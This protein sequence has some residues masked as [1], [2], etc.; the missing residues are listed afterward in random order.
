VIDPGRWINGISCPSP[1]LCVVVD[2]RGGVLT[3]TKPTGG[4][5]A[6]SKRLQ[7]SR[8]ALTTISCPSTRLCVA[9]EAS[10]S[11]LI[12]TNPSGG[13]IAWH[14]LTVAHGAYDQLQAVSCATT[15]LCVAT[16]YTQTVSIDAM[17]STN[18]TVARSWHDRADLDDRPHEGNLWSGVACGAPNLCVAIDGSQ[19][20]APTVSASTQP[21][22]KWRIADF[23]GTENYYANL[24]GVACAGASLCAIVGGDGSVIVGT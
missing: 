11:L 2:R 8:F 15:K 18:P 13:A 5:R 7:L 10:K 9:T 17:S 16:D 1:S 21:T 20:G 3:S 22:R 6:W 19:F 12:S 14:Q 23:P 4:R 24:N